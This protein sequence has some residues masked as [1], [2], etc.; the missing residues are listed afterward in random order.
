M[1]DTFY[2]VAKY[3]KVL[4]NPRDSSKKGIHAV[5]E[6]WQT[7]EAIKVT[8]NLKKRD[9]TEGFIILDVGRA[10]IVKGGVEGRTFEEYWQYYATNYAEH[11]NAWLQKE[12]NQQNNNV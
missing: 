8:K 11:I 12:L 7:N 2:L 3:T 4:R 6:A 9:L 1:A 10:K 5:A